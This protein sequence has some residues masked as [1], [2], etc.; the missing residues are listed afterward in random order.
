MKWGLWLKCQ[1]VTETMPILHFMLSSCFLLFSYCHTLVCHGCKDP[2][3]EKLF[4]REKWLQNY[5]NM[6][7]LHSSE[8]V[9]KCVELT[10]INDSFCFEIKLL[11]HRH[12]EWSAGTMLWYFR[13]CRVRLGECL[14][15]C[16]PLG[17]KLII[18]APLVL[19]EYCICLSLDHFLYQLFS[20]SWIFGS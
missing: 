5:W 19:N 3:K 11:K 1:M 15:W 18:V 7:T 14:V 2:P 13:R 10:T 17:E 12:S 6:W 20:L 8:I 4:Y 9:F 16:L